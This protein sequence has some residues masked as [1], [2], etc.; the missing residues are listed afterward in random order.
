[1]G[2][3]TS[4]STI[5]K[6]VCLF[7]SQIELNQEEMK[8]SNNPQLQSPPPEIVQSHIA[9]SIIPQG[10]IIQ[11]SLGQSNINSK[12]VLKFSTLQTNSFDLSSQV[13]ELEISK[14]I[15]DKINDIRFRPEE[16]L[17]DA[18]KRGLSKPFQ[19]TIAHIN[20]TSMRPDMFIW[21]D[22]KYNLLKANDINGLCKDKYKHDAFFVKFKPTNISMVSSDEIVWQLIESYDNDDRLK[23]IKNEY[24]HCVISA[25]L[26][27]N[28][29][30]V[31]FVF[32]Y[33]D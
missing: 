24:S 14:L 23:I 31:H 4:C 22:K 1:M 32:L 20:Q 33:K 2:T 29:L 19:I 26:I 8:R 9:Q 21:S 12:E 6:K 5:C 10:N 17:E 18:T 3:V 7:E 16:Y 30:D 28:G 27:Q 25:V 13:S 11:S 15:F